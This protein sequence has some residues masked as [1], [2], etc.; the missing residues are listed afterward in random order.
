[1]VRVMEALQPEQ[2]AMRAS[3]RPID[4]MHLAKQALGDPGLEVEIL[5][6]FD[7]IVATHFTGL[8]GSTTTPELMH[9]VHMI[10]TGA[11]GV[12]AWSLAEHAHVME[13]ELGNGEPVNP[14]RVHDIHIAV[15]EVR[16]FIAGRIAQD[17]AENP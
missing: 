9:H 4:M 16:S 2:Q 6:R 3:G 14:E 12:G 7:A 1:M 10:K 5:R 13:T 15:E 8:E 17:E 11:A